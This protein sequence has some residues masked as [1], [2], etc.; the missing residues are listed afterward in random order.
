MNVHTGARAAGLLP[1]AKATRP[2][3]LHE[4]RSFGCLILLSPPTVQGLGN[5]QALGKIRGAMVHWI[6]PKARIFPVR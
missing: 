2:Q 5:L 3:R 1:T 6:F 4:P